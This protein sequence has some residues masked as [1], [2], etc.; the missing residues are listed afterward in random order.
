V[1]P[2]ADSSPSQ[3][4]PPA[5]NVPAATL[6]LAAPEAAPAKRAGKETFVPNTGSLRLF[7]SADKPVTAPAT[8]TPRGKLFPQGSEGKIASAP[9]RVMRYEDVAAGAALV[10]LAPRPAKS[11]S[12]NVPP[13]APR[14]PPAA[15]A[16]RDSEPQVQRL[17]PVDRTLPRPQLPP[18]VKL[19]QE[20]IEI[21]PETGK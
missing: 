6:N 11:A 18:G 12:G 1:N 4:K 3:P 17:P 20:P 15:T 10:P 13:P 7:R 16:P 5:A 2:V 19:P 21:Y 8:G 14:T 9:V